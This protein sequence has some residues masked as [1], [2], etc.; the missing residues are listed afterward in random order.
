MLLDTSSCRNIIKGSL[1][2]QFNLQLAMCIL[3]QP[4]Q[5]RVANDMTMLLKT[6][7]AL[8][9]CMGEDGKD[10]TEFLAMCLV[11]DIEPDLVLGLTFLREHRPTIA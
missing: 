5:M 8:S 1:A 7:M 10:M 3:P 4:L 11:A 2:D 6:N 9:I